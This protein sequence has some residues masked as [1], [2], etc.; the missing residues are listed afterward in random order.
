MRMP[1]PPRRPCSATSS[2]RKETSPDRR[3]PST[4]RSR[5]GAS[6]T[7]RWVGRRTPVPRPDRPVRR[8]PGRRRGLHRRGA[9]HLP[10]DRPPPGEAWALQNLAWI[11]FVR[12]QRRRGRAPT[13]CVGHRVRRARRLGRPEL[14]ARPA[15]VG[16]L[17][18]G[19][20]RRGQP[21]RRADPAGSDGA[22]QPMGRRDHAGA[23]RQRL[24]LARR[25]RPGPRVRDRVARGLPD[26]RRRVGRAAVARAGGTSR[27]TPSSAP[28]RP[29]PSSTRPKGSRGASPIW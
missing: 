15:R 21:A 26:A 20:A 9:G 19:P 22:G 18:P 6:S 3:R 25:P 23:P 14:G 1:W 11:S 24:L 10:L 12:G 4:T 5:A 2:S 7:T 13:R 29:S 16:A 17:H 8:H 28:P 27:S